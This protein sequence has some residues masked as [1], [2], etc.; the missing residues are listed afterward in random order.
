MNLDEAISL[1][2]AHAEK[3]TRSFADFFG[4]KTPDPE[5]TTY[6]HVTT[7]A[8]IYLVVGVTLQ[9]SFIGGMK[10]AD[11]SWLDWAVTQ[12]VFWVTIGFIVHLASRLLPPKCPS[13]GF[14]VTF[15]VMPVAFLCGAYAS[16]LGFC[17]NYLLKFGEWDFNTVP[18]FFHMIVQV[19]I[20]CLYM[21]R[22]IRHHCFESKNSSRL[23]TS[24]VVIFVLSVDLVVVFGN[25]FMPTPPKAPTVETGN[26]NK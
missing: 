13:N 16:S 3:H 12:L 25:V 1:A 14:L 19:M 24:L 9:N 23:I 6:E 26:V 21:P 7:G 20:I 10:F 18:H 17:V 22:D 11:I 8:L 2:K 4:A 15:R 5:F